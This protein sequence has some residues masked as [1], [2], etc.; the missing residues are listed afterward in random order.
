MRSHTIFH[1][2]PPPGNSSNVLTLLSTVYNILSSEKLKI[3]LPFSNNISP[4]NTAIDVWNK[5]TIAE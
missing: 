4:L 1:L 5:Y 2:T 3:S